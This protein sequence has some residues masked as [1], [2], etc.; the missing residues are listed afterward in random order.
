[1]VKLLEIKIEA[2]NCKSMTNKVIMSAALIHAV[3]II[4]GGPAG[5]TAALYAGRYLLKPIVIEGTQEYDYRPGGQ[6]T[7]TSDIENF[8]GFP[9]GIDGYELIE[10]HK[11]GAIRWG[12]TIIEKSVTKV[13]FTAP[14]FKI[15]LDN[16]ETPLLAQTVIIAT[17]AS[18]NKLGIKG[19]S[20]F[21]M[22]A[23]ISACA[24]CDGASP[25][26]DN[27]V[28]CVVGGGDS[29]M[30]EALVLAKYASKVYILHRSTHF[31][32]SKVMLQRAKNHPKIEFMTNCIVT[33]ACGTDKL[34]KL[35]IQRTDLNQTI[36]LHTSGLFYAIGHTPHTELFVHTGLEIDDDK[37]IVTKHK[38]RATNIP[39]IFACG[40]VQDKIYRQ[41]I[42]SDGSGSEAAIDAERYLS[43]LTF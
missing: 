33:E 14:P 34:E 24:T 32:A 11:Q 37:Y 43:A 40:D 27:R 38:S 1:L 10:K 9:E 28:V 17:G 16:E 26:F 5:L 22:K 42:T 12:A 31:K 35:I 2:L 15:Y 41:A 23:G 18:T 4:G 29:A 19:E 30:E 21:Y 6:L 39:G 25:L 8:P 7:M 13:D 3:I 20:Q 36:E